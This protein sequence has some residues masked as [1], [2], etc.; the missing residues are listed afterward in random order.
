MELPSNEDRVVESL[1]EFHKN[2]DSDAEINPEQHYNHYGDRGIVDLFVDGDVNDLPQQWL[3]EAKSESAVRSATGA[4]EI[5]RQF[6][7]MR[8]FFFKGSEYEP[9]FVHYKLVFIPTQ[10]NI[11]H[12]IT[13]N[14]LYQEL[15]GH[16]DEGD[17][18]F[19]T[20][21]ELYIPS[22]DSTVEIGGSYDFDD[23]VFWYHLFDI[24]RSFAKDLQETFEGIVGPLNETE[25]TELS[26][27]TIS[28][29]S[30]ELT[31]ELGTKK[32]IGKGGFAGAAPGST[33]TVE[34][35]EELPGGRREF[36]ISVEPPENADLKS[37]PWKG[38]QKVSN[39][40]LVIL[41]AEEL[42]L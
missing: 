18:I 13:N 31:I 17:T 14:S 32:T 27:H 4:N 29:T 16:E 37:Y 35:I 6:N 42:G 34:K 10:Y 40:S 15:I 9:E 33:I 28:T 8:D 2:Q 20:T 11:R 12:L 21:I 22:R 25:T 5:I 19:R 7:R 41:F 1:I 36:T 26:E 30:G 3:Y 23:E 24:D 39:S 38:D